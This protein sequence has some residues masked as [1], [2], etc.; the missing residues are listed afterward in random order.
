ME[1]VFKF[2]PARFL[3]Q[4]CTGAH[5]LMDRLFKMRQAFDAISQSAPAADAILCAAFCTD[6]LYRLL[7]AGIHRVAPSHIHV[8]AYVRCLFREGERERER[9]RE[10]FSLPARNRNCTGT[11]ICDH[12]KTLE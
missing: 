2:M 6:D 3:R 5:R 1:C 7:D 10:G 12:L 11:V 9:A 8:H 4:S